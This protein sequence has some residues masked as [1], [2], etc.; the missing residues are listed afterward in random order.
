M[1]AEEGVETSST[2]YTSTTSMCQS[3]CWNFIHSSY[4]DF[5]HVTIRMLNNLKESIHPAAA[6][7]ARTHTHTHTPACIHSHIHLPMCILEMERKWWGNGGENNWPIILDV[8]TCTH[9]TQHCHGNSMETSRQT[10]HKHRLYLYIL[11]FWFTSYSENNLL[12]GHI[13]CWNPLVTFLKLPVNQVSVSHIS[14]LC[15]KLK[16][17][18]PSFAAYCHIV[19]ILALMGMAT[20]TG[21]NW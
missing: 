17:L 12:H 9:V 21:I 3:K 16:Q 5:V 4:M 1:L 6:A 15:S 13:L 18:A 8:G 10:I 14:L 7:H 19:Y 20:P 2:F 11:H